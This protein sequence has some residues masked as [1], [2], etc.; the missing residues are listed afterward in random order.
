MLSLARHSAVQMRA[1]LRFAP[2]G[3]V[4]RRGNEC[5]VLPV[6]HFSAAKQGR[7]ICV[8]SGKG[9]VGKTTSAASLSW[10]LAERGHKTCVIDFDIGL[11][12]LGEFQTPLRRRVMHSI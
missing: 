12:N 1:A 10:G 7:V 5:F 9:G 2:A 11:R 3:A 4:S 8:T 6:A